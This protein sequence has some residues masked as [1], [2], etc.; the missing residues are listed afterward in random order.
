MFS[1]FTFHVVDSNN[2]GLRESVEE[3]HALAAN[4]L[5]AVA[6]FHAAAALVHHFVWKDDV[7]RRMSPKR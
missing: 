2:K 1:T 7:L 5:L 4:T 3:W 6:F